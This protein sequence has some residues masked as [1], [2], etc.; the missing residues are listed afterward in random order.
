MQSTERLS[1]SRPR[2]RVLCAGMAMAFCVYYFNYG[3]TF[4]EGVTEASGFFTLAARLIA[5]GVVVAALAP[6]R[7][8]HASIV[9][10]VLLYLA[11]ACSWLLAVAFYGGTNDSLFLNTLIQLPLLVAFGSTRRP[12][13]YPRLLR[14]TGTV[15]ALQ[16]VLDGAVW[17]A[18]ISLWESEAFVGGVGNPSSFGFL[19]SLLLGFYLFHPAS[20]P[21]RVP[22][23]LS[24]A[25]GAIMSK[26]LLAVLAVALVVALWVAGGLKRLV[27]GAL[28]ITC[29]SVALLSLLPKDE[30]IG[31]V[32]HKLSAAGALVGLVEYDIESSGSVYI[33]LQMHDETLAELAREPWRLL[34]GH[35]GR[36]AYWPMDSQLLA[37]LGSFGALMLAVFLL[38]HGVWLARAYALR[39]VDGGF[40][41][42][43][44]TL[45]TLIFTTNRILD[46]F[47]LA[48][49][50][51][52]LVASLLNSKRPQRSLGGRHHRPEVV[53]C[54]ADPVG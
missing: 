52:A 39:R 19:C 42:V 27:V 49:M 34:T 13:D 11:A 17:V 43:S 32:E 30:E 47:P 51:F 18:G 37:Y 10:C 22:M 31:F 7:V 14:F 48:A 44:M 9:I 8:H 36:L 54:L 23:A 28:L 12:I 21:G 24:M 41:F 3:A 38:L 2:W 25:V 40:A 16:L 1:M 20:G 45:F 46:Y 29:V 33:R 53:D 4:D 15:L 6:F 26:A 35:L 5:V 50:Y